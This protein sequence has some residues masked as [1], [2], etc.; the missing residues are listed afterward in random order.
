MA[1]PTG[2]DGQSWKDFAPNPSIGASTIERAL[3]ISASVYYEAPTGLFAACLTGVIGTV[4]PFGTSSF[5]IDDS[6]SPDIQQL[7][8]S[9]STTTAPGIFDSIFFIIVTQQLQFSINDGNFH[10]AFIPGYGDP[11]EQSGSRKGLL[12]TSLSAQPQETVADSPHMSMEPADF[13]SALKLTGDMWF[14]SGVLSVAPGLK[15]IDS[16]VSGALYTGSFLTAR[17]TESVTELATRFGTADAPANKFLGLKIVVVDEG[18][19]TVNSGGIGPLIRNDTW[20]G[21]FFMPNS[22]SVAVFGTD[23]EFLVPSGNF[24][25]LTGADIIS[26]SLNVFSGSIY[27]QGNNVRLEI[28]GQSSSMFINNQPVASV[29]VSNVRV[30]QVLNEPELPD[31]VIYLTPSAST[32]NLDEAFIRTS[33]SWVNL[34]T[35]SVDQDVFDG[36]FFGL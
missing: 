3:P 16:A 14:A 7:S 19:V 25:V 33:G 30:D 18:L 11:L 26:G 27:I 31:G 28:S 5:T 8:W 23:K 21:G 17:S 34:V 22:N 6:T 36:G 29:T 12:I 24:T 20:G 32:S 9:L 4:F 13:E 10:F 35:Q 2:S 15:M 1:I